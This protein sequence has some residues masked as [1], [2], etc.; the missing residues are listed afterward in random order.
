VIFEGYLLLAM[1]ILGSS[2]VIQSFVSRLSSVKAGAE[3]VELSLSS[4]A[5]S[6]VINSQPELA[7]ET[8]S[9]NA[10]VGDT[11]NPGL[12]Y[13]ADLGRIVASDQRYL[14]LYD[15]KRNGGEAPAPYK[16]SDSSGS[17]REFANDFV[18][19]LANCQTALWSATGA[20]PM[21]P[22]AYWTL[23]EPALEF[24]DAVKYRASGP[25]VDAIVKN[26]A[27]AYATMASEALSE[28]FV[29]K[30]GLI[31]SS[32]RSKSTNDVNKM[33]EVSKDLSEYDDVAAACKA[34]KNAACGEGILHEA[35]P[36]PGQ[37][38][39]FRYGHAMRCSES[40]P[41]GGVP[42][43]D[44]PDI[45][46]LISYKIQANLKRS[47]D[48]W[49]GRPYAAFLAASV[50]SILDQN[51][52]AI[53]EI[54]N[55]L[56]DRTDEAW[57]N[58]YDLRM[59]TVRAALTEYWITSDVVV[60]S[61]ASLE[62]FHITQLGEIV[63]ELMR[64]PEYDDRRDN[65]WRSKDK[66]PTLEVEYAYDGDRE[67]GLPEKIMTAE[68]QSKEDLAT[69]KYTQITYMIKYIDR[70]FKERDFDRG[71]RI[72]NAE[73]ML[74]ELNSIDFGC[75]YHYEHAEEIPY[76]RAQIYRLNAH[77]KYYQYQ[78]I[79]KTLNADKK[80][81]SFWVRLDLRLRDFSYWSRKSEI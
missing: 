24:S 60:A 7:S 43:A 48:Q 81:K 17:L 57:K 69:I 41:F 10:A 29:T 18:A 66:N 32:S 26:V 53:E 6:P 54:D 4:S 47:Y 21:S 13:L 76:S 55:W 20:S 67:C 5:A 74:K 72:E 30:R 42:R 78:D 65:Y 62:E 50:L 11:A 38:K 36:Q 52:A 64:I 27:D 44:G 25:I 8:V 37:N 71:D 77:W 1:F 80:K 22:K 34:L 28:V 12:Q 63:W 39:G 68:D 33:K 49:S 51:R 19:P 23:L 40:P 31:N 75:L 35:S 2:D 15:S 9:P 79:E 16:V 45:E 14:A 59:E 61:N 46:K 3:G 73:K 56:H 58:W 70:A